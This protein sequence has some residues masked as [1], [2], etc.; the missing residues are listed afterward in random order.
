[1]SVGSLGLN[2]LNRPVPLTYEQGGAGF[3]DNLKKANE[4]AKK[5]KIFSKIGAVGDAVGATDYLNKKTGGYYGKAITEGKKRGYGKKRGKRG[6]RTS[7]R[8]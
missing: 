6:K 5:H 2:A 1:M 8:S 7:R 4:W 3:L